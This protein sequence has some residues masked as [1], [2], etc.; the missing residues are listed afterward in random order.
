MR[1]ILILSPTKSIDVLI[2]KGN[3]SAIEVKVAIPYY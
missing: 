1:L 2:E 3:V